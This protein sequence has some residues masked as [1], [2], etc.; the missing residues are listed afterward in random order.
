MNNSKAE[1][2]PIV[3]KCRRLY[4]EVQN[5]INNLQRISEDRMKKRYSYLDK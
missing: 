5:D 1:P 2:D 4:T 3:L